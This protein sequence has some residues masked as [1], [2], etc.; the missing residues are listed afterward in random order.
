MRR[1]HASRL[2]LAL[3]L[4]G[5]F[6]AFPSFASALPAVEVTGTVTAADTGAK[7]AGIRVY[8]H[9]ETA[10]TTTYIGETTTD[11]EGR[12][13]LS[14]IDH[15][16]GSVRIAASDPTGVYDGTVSSEIVVESLGEV[17]QV[18]LSLNRDNRAPVTEISS[19][20]HVYF[21]KALADAAGL[22]DDFIRWALVQNGTR[23]LELQ[24]YD[25]WYWDGDYWG[26]YNG[27][28]VR[29]LDYSV[30]GGSWIKTSPSNATRID[31]Y[32]KRAL[33]MSKVLPSFSEGVHSISHRAVD[34]NG[35]VG[36]TET[37]V[38]VVDTR[39][40]VTKY[41]KKTATMQRLRL[42]AYDAVTGVSGTFMRNGK[43]GSFKYGTSVSVPT[44][45]SKYVQFY[46]TDKAG[47]TEG[48]KTLK[49]SAPASV[50]TPKPT[51]SSISDART[52]KVTG[53]VYGRS[54][55]RGYVRI[56]KLTNGRYK[57]VAK[58]AFTENSDGKYRVSM[59]LKKGTYRF[60]TA[61]GSY[62]STWANPPVTSKISSRVTVW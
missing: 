5:A 54:K 45:G 10:S 51:T 7:L 37:N 36:K 21:S 23:T 27:S 13:T 22:P 33:W 24:A 14:S 57:Y 15:G 60:K 18:N 1:R 52:F 29:S 25:Y 42:A 2:F 58:K 9:Y 31:W 48:I 4:I 61:Y 59:K 53:S 6:L 11:A 28:G 26:S 3:C 49:V 34:M 12:Y 32:G 55:A 39:T 43:T 16:A 20:R 46:S 44:K 56:Y 40:P 38:I 19:V 47:N 30:D 8:G 50:S 35:N 41:N 62:S 17:K